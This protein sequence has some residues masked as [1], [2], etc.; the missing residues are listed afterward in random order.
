MS[1]FPRG[2]NIHNDKPGLLPGFSQSMAVRYHLDMF[3]LV[4]N[5]MM[6][7]KRVEERAQSDTG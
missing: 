4:R 7:R 2:L 1:L 5:S 3:Y 6:V